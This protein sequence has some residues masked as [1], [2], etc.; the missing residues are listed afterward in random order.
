MRCPDRFRLLLLWTCAALTLPAPALAADLYVSGVIGIS[1]ATGD[2]KFTQDLSDI[3]RDDDD[4]TSPVYGGAA[5]VSGVV[6]LR[7]AH[8]VLDRSRRGEP[9]RPMRLFHWSNTYLT[10]LFAAVALDALI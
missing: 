8:R 5:V 6:F 9:V 7:E 2:T 3:P 1:H 10:I 4:D